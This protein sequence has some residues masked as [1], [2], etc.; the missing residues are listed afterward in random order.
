V[1]WKFLVAI[2]NTD[3]LTETFVFFIQ[4][5]QGI[6]HLEVCLISSVSLDA[7][8]QDH[9]QG[10]MSRVLPLEVSKE[11]KYSMDFIQTLFL[12]NHETLVHTS[13]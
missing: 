13:S 1:Y 7:F 4:V 9:I 2:R 3:N 10:V 8:V 12:Q 5:I 6:K 11:Y